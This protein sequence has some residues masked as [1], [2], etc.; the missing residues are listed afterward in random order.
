[1]PKEINSYNKERKLEMVIQI[2]QYKNGQKHTSVRQYDNISDFEKDCMI[3]K[4][5]DHWVGHRIFNDIT[6]KQFNQLNETQINNL[7][8]TANF[9]RDAYVQYYGAK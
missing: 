9:D 3:L 4:I 5:A 8:C 2:F 1:M 6:L 7:T